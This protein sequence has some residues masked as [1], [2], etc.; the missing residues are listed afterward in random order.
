[1]EVVG[2]PRSVDARLRRWAHG[3][4]SIAGKSRFDP[5]DAGMPEVLSRRMT[6][7]RRRGLLQLTR[8][9]LLSPGGEVTLLDLTRSFVSCASTDWVLGCS[10]SPA[11]S[12]HRPP[13]RHG[14]RRLYPSHLYRD[15][16]LILGE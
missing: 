1:M 6:E 9:G 11:L 12:H 7:Y 4:R 13:R 2:R 14:G 10:Q 3:D 8:P 15:Y 16:S 5:V